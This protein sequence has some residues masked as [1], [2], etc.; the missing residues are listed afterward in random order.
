MRMNLLD[1]KSKRSSKSYE[2]IQPLSSE[3]ISGRAVF[4]RAQETR[5]VRSCR[6]QNV[7]S[8]Y[9]ISKNEK[10]RP[11]ILRTT[12]SI[13]GLSKYEHY[14]RTCDE[15]LRGSGGS[16]TGLNTGATKL[17]YH[18]SKNISHFLHFHTKAKCLTELIINKKTVEERADPH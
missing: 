15:L 18:I 14:N 6:G 1:E 11:E 3:R 8:G 2:S 12:N 13:L 16:Q 17:F 10:R 5:P 4:E 7:C 9:L